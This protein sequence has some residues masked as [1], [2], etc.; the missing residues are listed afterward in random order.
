MSIIVKEK[1][2]G[3]TRSS[4]RNASAEI[5]YIIH[6]TAGEDEEQAET[7]LLEEAP[8]TYRGLIQ[9][10]IGFFEE[11]KT[12]DGKPDQY[13]QASIRY[14]RAGD[15]QARPPGTSQIRYRTTGGTQHVSNSLSTRHAYPQEG[16]TAVDFGNAVNVGSDSTVEGFDKYVP[17]LEW[18]ETHVFTPEQVTPEKLTTWYRMTGTTNV[19][20]WRIFAAEECLFLGIE[21]G[22]RDDGNHEITFSFSATPNALINGIGPITG[23]DGPD[24]TKIDKRGWDLLWVWYKEAVDDLTGKHLLPIPQQVNVEKVYES[25]DFNELGLG[26][27]T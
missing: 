4:G 15:I 18:T 7:A 11:L 5:I 1:F 21:G 6:A 3:R 9:E 8:S 23:T 16:E 24:N 17:V 22:E 13:W 14:T 26:T 25:T 10:G 19:A 20:P 12:G 27:T 2:L